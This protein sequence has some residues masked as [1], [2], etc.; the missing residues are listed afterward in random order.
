MD[1]EKGINGCKK[2]CFGSKMCQ[3]ETKSFQKPIRASFG[4]RNSK[5]KK[6]SS[7]NK[8]SSV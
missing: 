6:E 3:T 4:N 5:T 8:Q 7:S 1:L 2:L